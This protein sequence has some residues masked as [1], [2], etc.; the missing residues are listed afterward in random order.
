MPTSRVEWPLA[1]ADG[2]VCPGGLIMPMVSAP[3]TPAR[4][5]RMSRSSGSADR[6]DASAFGL[7]HAGGDLPA[8]PAD[9]RHGRLIMRSMEVPCGYQR[10][11][12]RQDSATTVQRLKERPDIPWSG[13]P[14][15]S[16]SRRG[17]NLATYLAEP[18]HPAL[19]APLRNRAALDFGMVGR[20]RPAPRT[21]TTPH[22]EP[23]R[24]EQAAQLSDLGSHALVELGAAPF[25]RSAAEP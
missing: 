10:D 18:H 4:S 5:A 25:L 22:K 13:L 11:V 1:S 3:P 2:S 16:T 17:C 15:H 21:S 7:S 6:A 14:K 20:G 12:A 24:R 8:C 19:I 23:A 9:A